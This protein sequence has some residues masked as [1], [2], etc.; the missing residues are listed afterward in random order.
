[1]RVCNE[2]DAWVGLVHRRCP[3]CGYG[4]SHHEPSPRYIELRS[5]E[6]R[7][8]WDQLEHEARKHDCSRDHVAYWSEL[9]IP[10]CSTRTGRVSR[11]RVSA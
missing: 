4:R 2:C 9:A 3:F 10:K 6:V 5:A 8:H 11:K 1:M 7:E